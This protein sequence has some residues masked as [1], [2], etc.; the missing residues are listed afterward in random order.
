MFVFPDGRKM[1]V[2]PLPSEIADKYIPGQMFKNQASLPSLPVNSLEQSL[3]KYLTAL[4]V[5]HLPPAGN[6]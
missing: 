5:C 1:R 3:S 4:E 2:P 6:A